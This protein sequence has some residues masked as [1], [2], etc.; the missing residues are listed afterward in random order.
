MSADRSVTPRFSADGIGETDL[1]RVDAHTVQP[2]EYDE[3]PGLTDAMM[4]RADHYVGDR[5][6]RRGRPPKAGAKV[7]VSIRLSP[8]ALAYFRSGGPGWQTRIDDILCK[9]AE[10]EGAPVRDGD[11]CAGGGRVPMSHK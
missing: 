11:H 2:E 8:A 3:L 7:A 4:A 5:L 9:V 6:V 10:A 1:A